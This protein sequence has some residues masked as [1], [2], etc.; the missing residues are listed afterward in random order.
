MSYVRWVP[1]RLSVLD[2]SPISEGSTGSD[3]LRDTVD[4]ARPADDLG[5]TRYW[6]AEH[7]GGAMLAGP[8]PEALIGPSRPPRAIRVG[9][10]GMMIPNYTPLKVVEISRALRPPPGAHRPR[11]RPRAGHRSGHHARP[12]A[13]PPHPRARRLPQSARGAAGLLR[14]RPARRPPVRAA[15]GAARPPRGARAVAA[16]IVGAER[17]LGRAARPAVRVRGLHQ[18]WRRRAG[19]DLPPALRRRGAPGRPAPDGRGVGPGG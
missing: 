9:T 15:V 5:Y 12:P 13:R 3:A 16:R 14:G 2:Q 10:G 6:V 18:P 11:P 19:R 1:L 8:S 17:D 4:L 7:H